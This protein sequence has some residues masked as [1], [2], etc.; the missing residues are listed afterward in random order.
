MKTKVSA[1]LV[2]LLV[3]FLLLTVTSL[4]Q[5]KDP[6]GA[7]ASSINKHAASAEGAAEAR[8]QIA[9]QARMT[10]ADI[11]AQQKR[12]RLGLGEVA[13]ANALARASG[14][15][16]EEV[17]SM[18]RASPEGRGWGRIAQDLGVN[19]GEAVSSVKKV[20]EGTERSLK[21]RIKKAKKEG[22]PGRQF[23]EGHPG[24][25]RGQGRPF[26]EGGPPGQEK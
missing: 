25:A 15:S 13:I 1:A 3:S 23:D 9:K 20:E 6:L 18:R 11:A 16:F 4:G 5:E 26:K 22:K 7:A 17:V 14:K 10:E 8:R 19:L 12:S 21:A 24:K 2:V